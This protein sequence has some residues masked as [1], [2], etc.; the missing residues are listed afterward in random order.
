MSNISQEEITALLGDAVRAPSGDNAQPWR[1]RMDGPI[2]SIYNIPGIHNPHLDF[3]ER[4]AYI[5]HG[6]LIENLLISAPHYGYTAVID[7]FPDAAD[8]DLVARVHFAK[9]D[10]HNDPLYSAI[11]SRATN[12]HSFEE[13]PLKHTTKEALISSVKEIAHTKLVLI[14]DPEGRRGIGHVASRA[15][16]VIL[17]DEAITRSFFSGMVWTA[18]EER[19]KKSGFFVRSLEFNP[20]QLCVF[21]LASK[22]S[23]MRLFRKIHLPHFIAHEDAKLYATGSAAGGV[24]ILDDSK[25]SYFMAGRALERIWLTA[26]AEGLAFQPLIGTCF[27]AYKSETGRAALSDSHARDMRIAFAKAKQILGVKEEI[28]ALLFRV[29]VAPPPSTRS[30]RRDVSIEFV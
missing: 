20:I 22:P 30:S 6:A 9:R 18:E 29:G 25:E 19:E 27:I 8:T 15:E 16:V 10:I 3:E 4:G 5:A 23:I 12:H 13:K 1:F 21:W 14:T 26:T 2:L 24:L 17:E 7:L 11:Q 28:I